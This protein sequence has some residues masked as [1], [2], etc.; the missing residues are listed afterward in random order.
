MLEKL[1][2]GIYRVCIPFEDIYTAS[3]ILVER[4]SAIIFDTG[5]T[6]KD[7]VGYIIPAV[8]NLRVP[9]K[10]IIISHMHG[11][12]CGGLDVLRDKYPNAVVGLFSKEI[13]NA[14]YFV[15]GEIIMDR[16]QV[17]NLKGHSEDCLSIYDIKTKTLLTG[18]CLQLCGV[19]R[20]GTSAPDMAEYFKT[21]D[22]VKEFKP[23]AIIASH[24]YVP[25]GSI[26]E[27]EN[28][29]SYLDECK[30]S[31]ERICTLAKRNP[32]LDGAALVELFHSE[33]KNMPQLNPDT[34][35]KMLGRD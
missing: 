3:F 13:E 23:D 16:F 18:D 15:D 31:V 11:D 34:V 19:G 8:E 29:E 21:I 7:A 6:K 12:H 17:F 5:T 1:K 24:E 20:Y 14:Y 33:Y 22:R 10:Y 35:S 27:G 26:A 2:E 32:L 28:V 25:L 4:N 30:T 9:I